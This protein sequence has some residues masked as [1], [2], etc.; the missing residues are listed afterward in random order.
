MKLRKK[1]VTITSL[2]LICWS[3]PG[4][5]LQQQIF[6]IPYFVLSES[7]LIV[8][9]DLNEQITVRD[10]QL[11]NHED[12]PPIDHIIS[13]YLEYANNPPSMS[14]FRPLKIELSD[15]TR[16]RIVENR[17]YYYNI[18]TDRGTIKGLLMLV[19]ESRTNK[20]HVIS[21]FY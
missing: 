18:W 20:L 7:E 4:F 19:R 15:A 16:D 11:R 3:Y 6:V 14:A 5:T 1:I 2:F 12:E 13:M 17:V 10:F 21:N 8:Y 9:T